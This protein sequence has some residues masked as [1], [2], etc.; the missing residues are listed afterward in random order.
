MVTRGLYKIE[1]FEN[2]CISSSSFRIS[3]ATDYHS[4]HII[5]HI[6]LLSSQPW[7]TQLYYTSIPVA[8]IK[9]SLKTFF[10]LL[11]LQQD[12]VLN[13]YEPMIKFKNSLEMEVND[14]LNSKFIH[15]INQSDVS[16]SVWFKNFI[17]SLILS[18]QKKRYERKKNLQQIS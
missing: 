6:F 3:L 12:P 18:T 5:M 14:C 2:Y 9:D 15:K 16:I 10:T 8:L 17:F 1:S 13:S 7:K 11:N 4:A